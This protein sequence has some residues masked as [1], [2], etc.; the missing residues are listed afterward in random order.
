MTPIL[1]NIIWHTFVGPHFQYTIGSHSVRRYVSGLPPIAA[2]RDT[3]HPDWHALD[4][5]MNPGEHVHCDGLEGSVPAEWRIEGEGLLLKM[6]W[7]GTG[8]LAHNPAPEAVRLHAHCA[9]AAV[10]LASLANP[11][12]FTSRTLE[13]GEYFGIFDGARLLAMAGSRRCA[14]GYSEITGVCTHPDFTGK[15]L[16]RR[17]VAKVLQRQLLLGER[18][19]LRVMSH[20]STARQLYLRA[21]FR[22][23]AQS[24]ARTLVRY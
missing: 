12:P 9:A 18:P 21:G 5:L 17:L 6:I 22:D 8:E 1:D 14:G 4:Q 16:A 7:K 15:G 23:Y 13:L 2:F 3:R 19:F 11:G 24:V 20:S 10:E